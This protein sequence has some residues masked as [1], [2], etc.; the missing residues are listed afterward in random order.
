MKSFEHLLSLWDF[1]VNYSHRED[2]FKN[3]ALNFGYSNRV[4]GTFI[5]RYL[6]KFCYS[7]S[8]EYNFGKHSGK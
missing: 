3:E 2:R 1:W 4:I 8:D 6:R 5:I 7:I